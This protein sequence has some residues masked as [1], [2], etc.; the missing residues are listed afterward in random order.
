MTLLKLSQIV[1]F[2]RNTAFCL[3]VILFIISNSLKI[4]CLFQNYLLFKTW[5]NMHTFKG[6]VFAV[7]TEEVWP[8]HLDSFQQSKKQQPGTC[9]TAQ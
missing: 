1:V 5:K 9:T 4:I 3:S 7:N 8:Q 6:Y 2:K